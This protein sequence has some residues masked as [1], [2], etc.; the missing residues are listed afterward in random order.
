MAVVHSFFYFVTSSVQLIIHSRAEFRD[1]RRSVAS[2]ETSLLCI[3]QKTSSLLA[4]HEPD[5][6]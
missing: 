6:L 2:W 5:K 3:W 4:V 1:F